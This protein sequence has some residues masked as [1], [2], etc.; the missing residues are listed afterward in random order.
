MKKKAIAVFDIGKTNKKILLLDFE[1]NLLEQ[2][3]AI[4]DQITDDDGFEC[5]DIERMEQWI[6]TALGKVVNSDTYDVVAVNFTTYGA[7]LMYLDENGQRLTP[8]YNYLKP[9]PDGIVEPLYEKYGGQQEFCRCTASPASGMLN[10]GF[11]ALW[12]KR[13]KPEIFDKVKTILHFP[14][15]LSYLFTGRTYSD[16]TSIGC[17]TS[18]WNFDKHTYHQWTSD[19]C[20]P[21][22][23][24]VSNFVTNEITIKGKKLLAGIGIHDSSSSLAPY[25]LN[26]NE[27]FLLLSTGTWCISMNPFNADPLTA[28]QL[29]HDCLSYMSIHQKPVKSARFFMGHIHDENVKWMNAFF[30]VEPKYYKTIGLQQEYFDTACQQTIFFKDSIPD[31]SA[32][33]SV[34]LSSFPNYEAAYHQMMVDLTRRCIDSMR[35]IIAHHDLTTSIYITGGFA[36]NAIFIQYI[37]RHFCD[38]DVYTSEVDNATAMGAALM[39]RKA[40]TDKGLELDLG[41][42]KWEKLVVAG[43]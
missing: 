7:S 38:K 12:L 11:Q 17:H 23:Q 28:E 18:L 32:D 4:Y 33:T 34:D 29:E 2:Q 26:T 15:Y 3:E 20:L 31:T 41:L 30:K 19:E 21:L 25:L 37:N 39:V 8:V 13:T 10:S 14:Q 24:P 40:L 42:K 5:D 9:M 36:R 35:H 16:F 22:P 6:Q 27:Q 43:K 1:L